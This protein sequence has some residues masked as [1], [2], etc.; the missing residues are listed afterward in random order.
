MTGHSVTELNVGP[1]PIEYTAIES[2]DCFVVVS[3]D[4]LKKAR[5][6]IGALPE[7]STLYAEESLELPETRATVVRLPFIR[8]ARKINRLSIGI[9]ALAAVLQDTG[10]FPADAY[11][12]AISTF[13]KGEIAD[14]SLRALKAGIELAAPELEA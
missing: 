5:Q 13:Q 6:R 4:G 11:G 1:T 14:V 12:K 3:D 2:P 10:M 8:T 9:V 7:T